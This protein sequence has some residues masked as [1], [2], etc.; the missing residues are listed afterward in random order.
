[1]EDMTKHFGVFFGS[2]CTYVGR[3]NNNTI[4]LGRRLYWYIYFA[5]YRRWCSTVVVCHTR[6]A[7][8]CFSCSASNAG[9]VPWAVR[10]VTVTSLDTL[11]TN[12]VTQLLSW[13]IAR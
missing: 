4:V 6:W 2:R 8:Q 3:P 9:R 11:L 7:L 12:D 1:V 10:H 13:Y 5:S